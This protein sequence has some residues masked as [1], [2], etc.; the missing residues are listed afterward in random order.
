MQPGVRAAVGFGTIS[1][2]LA[3]S[4]VFGGGPSGAGPPAVVCGATITTDTM[5]TSDLNC[6]SGNGIVIG[7]AGITLDLGG[8]SL[9]GSP[10]GIGVT[11]TGFDD[12]TVRN[13]AISGFAIAIEAGYATGNVFADLDVTVLAGDLTSGIILTAANRSQVHDNHMTGGGNAILLA[14]DP[15][16]PSDGAD[17][18][19]IVGNTISATL[20]AIELVGSSE[21][22]IAFNTVTG[23]AAAF[24]LGAGA[25]D[26]DVSANAATGGLTGVYID[27]FANLSNFVGGNVLKGHD[28]AGV[29][30][31]AGTSTTRLA[32]NVT[33]GNDVGIA[34][35]AP[36]TFLVGNI[37]NDNTTR[38]IDAVAGVT[39]GGSNRASGN[40]APQCVNVDCS[41]SAKSAQADA[42]IR[43]PG[44]PT[45]PF[46]GP[47]VIGADGA[48]Q[49]RKVHAR[50]SGTGALKVKIRNTGDTPAAFV[51]AAPESESQE[52]ATRFQAGGNDVTALMR[53]GT[54]V[55]PLGPGESLV[56]DLTVRARATTNAGASMSYLVTASNVV[57]PSLV[58]A[59]GVV[60]RLLP[61]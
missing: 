8:H 60:A 11:N 18:N 31:D 25:S 16:D 59:V 36:G 21:N 39:D 42:M 50:P 57:E 40:P 43:K 44:I 2:L 7:A 55:V 17:R 35:K 48:G 33:S 1:T 5:L 12:L 4:F 38:G 52:F 45:R 23:S 28:S 22:T 58:D 30:V 29:F 56:L 26:N 37:A 54:F 53:A 32:A 13:G 51:V 3:A 27:P 47:G 19:R 20:Q 61:A 6:A 46:A 14:A 24:V 41:P 15:N 49:T 9:I 34:V 10:N